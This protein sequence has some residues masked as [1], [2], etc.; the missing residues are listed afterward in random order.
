MAEP[1][2]QKTWAYILGLMLL[3]VGFHQL[4]WHGGAPYPFTR[5][6][7]LSQNL[8]LIQA[9][10][11]I[12]LGFDIPKMVWGLGAGWD[13]FSSGQMGIFYPFHFIA[14]AFSSLIGQP[15]WQMEAL[16]LLHQMALVIMVMLWAP[17]SHLRKAFLSICLMFVPASFLLGMGWWGYGCAHVWWVGAILLVHRESAGSQPFHR[18]SHKLILAL[19][20]VFNFMAS[21][22]QM[23]AWGGLLLACWI[24]L[25]YPASQSRRIFYVLIFCALPLL[26]GLLYIKNLAIMSA[27]ISTRPDGII[28]HFSQSL[29]TALAAS[30]V[31]SLGGLPRMQIFIHE[32]LEGPAL[33]FQP[34]IFLCALLAIKQKRWSPLL[35]LAGCFVFLGAQSFPWLQNLNLGPF[36]GFRWTFKLTVLTAP[37]FILFFVLVLGARLKDRHVNGLLMALGVVS[38]VICF[39]CRGFNLMAE[40]YGTDKHAGQIVKEAKTCLSEAQIPKG[41]RLAFVGDYP[42]PPEPV[43]AA[44]LALT[45]N[46]VL[47]LDVGATHVYEHLESAEMAEGHLHMLGRYGNRYE[48]R[49]VREN[50]EHSI[51][52]FRFIGATHMFS[53]DAG[54]LKGEEVTSCSNAQG[55]KIFF[56]PI[57]KARA[58]TY[59][60]PYAYDDPTRIEKR[61]NGE[62][63]VSGERMT[64]PE[65]NT[66]APMS[67]IKEDAGWRGHPNPIN[68]IWGGLTVL[69]MGMAAFIFRRWP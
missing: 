18:H 9:Q 39:Q 26:P 51:E 11:Q 68:P 36:N 57:S 33:F 10:T 64:P 4:L 6:D 8:P 35:L 38:L 66:T 15:L 23:F 19:L 28:L 56:A 40:A 41:S 32:Y 48:S 13:P 43:P 52:S 50:W 63:W 62:L 46:A 7:N 65:L 54:L 12:Y 14:Y 69:L 27:G 67:W 59:P 61:A 60:S 44:A 3:A 49:F 42:G 1:P 2:S 34:A 47:L 17:G 22:P 30:L 58:G 25:S 53:L 45:G 16:F 37:F 21:H 55:E 20:L 29:W 24:L 31:G 5:D